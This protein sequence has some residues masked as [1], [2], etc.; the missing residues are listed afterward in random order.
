MGQ[1]DFQPAFVYMEIENEN[2]YIRGFDQRFGF[3][4]CA[5]KRK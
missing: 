3:F 1:A 4:L 5:Y 2:K